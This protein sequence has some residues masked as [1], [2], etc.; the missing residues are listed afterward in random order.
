VL[1]RDWIAS[2][3]ASLAPLA[4]QKQLSGWLEPLHGVLRAGNQS[5]QW[6]ASHRAGASVSELIA[7]GARELE[8]LENR[9]SGGSH[10]QA[11]DTLG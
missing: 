10:P 11:A 2:Q 6:L 3:L 1:A 9:L 7:A 4:E 8:Q 5:M